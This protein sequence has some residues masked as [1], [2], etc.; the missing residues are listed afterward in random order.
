MSENFSITGKIVGV[1]PRGNPKGEVQTFWT[2]EVQDD[3]NAQY[4]KKVSF[5]SHTKQGDPKPEFDIAWEALRNGKPITVEGYL[6]DNPQNADA[7]Y[8]NGTDIS[9]ASDN[10]APAQAANT[11]MSEQGK[12]DWGQPLDPAPTPVVSSPP[13]K[14][15][16]EEF[17]LRTCNIEMAWAYQTILD[18]APSDVIVTPDELSSKSFEL[19]Y[20]KRAD[21]QE[22]YEGGK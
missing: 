1:K 11:S 12:D 14:N 4:P 16:Y 6:S 7:P 17:D 19:I 13:K 21:A 2:L 9:W 5:S 10:A 18:R 8:K 20:K 15:G 3:P 22:L